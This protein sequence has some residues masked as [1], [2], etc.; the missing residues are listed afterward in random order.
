MSSIKKE[1]KPIYELFE[2]TNESFFNALYEL[3]NSDI[4]IPKNVIPSINHIMSE[5][6]YITSL[7]ESFDQMF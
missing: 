2:K 4:L 7:T 1:I 6:A 5:H 3:K